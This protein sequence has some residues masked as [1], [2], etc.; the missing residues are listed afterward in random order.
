M[1][2]D[3]VSKQ[4]EDKFLFFFSVFKEVI[5]RLDRK[6]LLR[7]A[8]WVTIAVGIYMVHK[9]SEDLPLDFTIKDDVIDAEFTILD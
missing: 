2:L 4:R 7:T 9:G 1:L 8:G 5:Q 3:V 6:R